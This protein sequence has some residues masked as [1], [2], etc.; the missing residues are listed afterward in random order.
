[1]Q[2]RVIIRVER[3]KRTVK[4][5]FVRLFRRS[6]EAEFLEREIMLDEGSANVDTDIFCS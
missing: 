2:R 1:M 3:P 4:D 5:W 6:G